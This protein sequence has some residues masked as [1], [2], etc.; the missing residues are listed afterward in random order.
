MAALLLGIA[1]TTWGLL[2]RV[3]EAKEKEAARQLE[4][5][6]SRGERLAKLEAQAQKA[7]AVEQQNRAEAG[8][9]LASERLVLVE[10][11]KV[12]AE[13][14]QS[15]SDAVRF[16]LQRRLLGQAD[17]EVQ[18]NTL[19]EISGRES[20]SRAKRNP[21]IRELLDRAALEMTPE[22]I[23]DNFPGMP[24][25]QAEILQTLAQTYDDIGE[26]DRAIEFYKR[27]LE[28]RRRCL[29]PTDYRIFSSLNNLGYAYRLRGNFSE[30]AKQHEEMLALLES[31]E[32]VDPSN[33]GSVSVVK[34]TPELK[35]EAF[36]ATMCNLGAALLDLGRNEEATQYLE[37]AR[38]SSEELS[39][40]FHPDTLAVLNNLA[41][42]YEITGRLEKYQSLR[43][44]LYHRALKHLGPDHPQTLHYMTGFALVCRTSGRLDEMRE[45]NR[46]RCGCLRRSS[47]RNTG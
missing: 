14:E 5:K 7:V 3:R 2:E 1:G 35:R 46:E 32:R 43:S 40:P 20:V 42:A 39:G 34:M 38:Q 27:S 47:V 17:V 33:P 41:M 24:L 12:R 23:E 29:A 9:R 26:L 6:R 36:G 10:A 44:E 45:L 37:K 19:L 31:P 18:A 11:E 13:T 22:N 25:V 15:I 4:S 16:F 21:T 28:L 30:S 8:E